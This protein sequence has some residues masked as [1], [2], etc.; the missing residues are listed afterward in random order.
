M[1]SK[2]QRHIVGTATGLHQSNPVQGG[3]EIISTL[4]DV[5]ANRQ[6]RQRAI[7]ELGIALESLTFDLECW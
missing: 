2:P 5:E 3:R 4:L 1:F 6:E 7:K